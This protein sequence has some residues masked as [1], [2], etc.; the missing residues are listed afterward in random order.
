M[1]TS[2]V[3]VALV[4]LVVFVGGLGVAGL[5]LVEGSDRRPVTTADGR[6]VD[7]GERWPGALDECVTD[8]EVEV[9]PNCYREPVQ[10]GW[11]V[12]QPASTASTLA[13]CGVGL[14][15]LLAADRDRTRAGLTQSVREQ[16]WFGFVALAMGPGSALFHGTLTLWGGWFD[17]LSMYALLA[18]ILATDLVRLRGTAAAYARW[19]WGAIAV[20]AVLKGLSGDASTYVFM[21]VAV[22]VGVFALVSWRRWLAGVGLQRSGRRLLLAYGLLFASIVPWLISNPTSGAPTDVPWHSAWHVLSAL[23]VGAY[24][25]YLRS[26]RPATVGMA[27]GG[28]GP[29]GS[30]EP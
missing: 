14:A 13:F 18:A 23:F 28:A 24:G 30:M 1:R 15:L 25:W 11:F 21:A 4:L 26:E 16:R 12:K 5:L 2:S 29:D 8:I 22:G 27:P 6:T 17:Q 10:R 7:I 19:F 3:R 9:L 20:A